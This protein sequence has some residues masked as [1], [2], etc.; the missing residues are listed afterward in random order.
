M[1][2]YN[3][4]VTGIEILWEAAEAGHTGAAEELRAIA[5]FINERAGRWS[6]MKYSKPTL[7]DRK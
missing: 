6:D 5:D 3:D 4:A 1:R 7:Q 2:Y